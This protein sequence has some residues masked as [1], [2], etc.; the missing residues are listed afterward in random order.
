MGL[1]AFGALASAVQAGQL[2]AMEQD[3]NDAA[4]ATDLSIALTRISLLETKLT[5]AKA[6]IS[7]LSTSSSTETSSITSICTAVGLNYYSFFRYWISI[8]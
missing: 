7:S 4:E 5:A 8:T 3:I 1:S 2:S 6:T